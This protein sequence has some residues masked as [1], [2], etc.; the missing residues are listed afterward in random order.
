L[1]FPLIVL[2]HQLVSCGVTPKLASLIVLAHQLSGVPGRKPS[3]AAVN[4]TQPMNV[5]GGP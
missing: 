5:V 1:K 3:R 2:A 4:P